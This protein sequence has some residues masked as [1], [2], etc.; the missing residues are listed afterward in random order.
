MLKV[1]AF[2]RVKIIM[3]TKRRP[4]AET[5]ATILKSLTGSLNEQAKQIKDL[6]VDKISL[7]KTI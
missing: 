1:G 5:F 7:Q 2:Q 4:T 3:T 6:Q